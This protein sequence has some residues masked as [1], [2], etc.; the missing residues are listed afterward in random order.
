MLAIIAP[1]FLPRAPI[2]NCRCRQ[3]PESAVC[4]NSLQL[5]G[6]SPLMGEQVKFPVELAHRDGLGV[7]HVVVDSFVHTTADGWLPFQHRHGGGQDSV[8]LR[9][10]SPPESETSWLLR[11][12]GWMQRAGGY[13]KWGAVGCRCPCWRCTTPTATPRALRLLL[14]TLLLPEPVGPTSMRPCRTTV[15]S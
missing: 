8:T 11:G 4:S 5:G 10:E 13:R 12:Q 7:E 1:G 2:P 14:L 15:V 9:R 6:H 3:Q